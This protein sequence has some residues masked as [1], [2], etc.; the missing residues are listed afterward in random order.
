MTKK[1]VPLKITQRVIEQDKADMARYMLQRDVEYHGGEFIWPEASEKDQKDFW[2]INIEVAIEGLIHFAREEGIHL[3]AG[4]ILK[5]IN[6]KWHGG[7]KW[8]T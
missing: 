5:K 1:I 2:K 4:R 7:H 6:K 8:Q 3:D